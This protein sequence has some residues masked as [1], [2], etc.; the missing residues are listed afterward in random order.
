M[1]KVLLVACSPRKNGNSDYLFSLAQEYYGTCDTL[2][3]RNEVLEGCIGCNYC[4]NKG[5]CYKDDNT[6]NL[7]KNMLGY[8]IVVFFSPVYFCGFS[9]HTKALID[10]SQFLYNTIG[11]NSGK[12]ALVVTFGAGKEYNYIGLDYGMRYF[13][14]AVKKD[15]YGV[16]PFGKTDSMPDIKTTETKLK[17]YE[18]LDNL[19]K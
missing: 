4:V 16:L 2:V 19:S 17:L 6:T 18:F 3:L 14:K 11:D 5:K 15:Y 1:K 9:S 13:A 7:L 10:R 12:L 8:D